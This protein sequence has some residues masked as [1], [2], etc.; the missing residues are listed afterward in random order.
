MTDSQVLALH[1]DLDRCLACH[2]NDLQDIVIPADFAWVTSDVRPWSGVV[3]M[4]SCSA[5]GLDQKLLSKVYLEQVLLVYDSYALYEVAGTTDHLVVREGEFGTRSATLFPGLTNA[6]ISFPDKGTALDYGCGRGAFLREI[7]DRLPAWSLVGADLTETNRLDVEGIPG[8]EYVTIPKLEVDR[9][10]DLISLL[11]VAEHLP[12]PAQVLAE[13]A[14]MLT[15]TGL[16]VIQVPSYESNPFDLVVFDHCSHFS[17]QSL[18]SLA[19]LAGLEVL[20]VSDNLISRELTLVAGRPRGRA[21]IYRPLHSREGG[22]PELAVEWLLA[23]RHMVRELTQGGYPVGILGAAIGA[24]W[25]DRCADSATSFFV[26]E[27]PDNAG[28]IFFGRPIMSPFQVPDGAQVLVPF[29]PEFSI[30]ISARLEATGISC[31]YPKG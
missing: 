12:N 16:I 29:R 4:A 20:L 2:S 6:G 7:S 5:C 8:A 18:R 3:G 17:M 15:E 22:C 1:P 13:L 23:C 21:N 28:R 9:R 27:A 31:H 11:H 25:L 24:L 14:S 10:F 19:G 26:D 30:P